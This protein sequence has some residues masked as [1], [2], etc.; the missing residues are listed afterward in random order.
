[1]NMHVVLNVPTRDQQGEDLALLCLQHTQLLAHLQVSIM[2][3]M[4]NQAVRL[5]Y[6]R[7][8]TETKE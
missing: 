6:K 2:W 8:C 4:E 3:E 1:M 5:G 7:A